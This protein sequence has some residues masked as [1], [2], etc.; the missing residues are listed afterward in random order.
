MYSYQKG[1]VKTAKLKR[2][3]VYRYSIALTLIAILSTIAFFNLFSALK[4]SDSTGIIVNISGKQRMLSQHIALDVYKIHNIKS[5]DTNLQLDTLVEELH[6]HTTEMALAN[7][8]L[9]TGQLSQTREYTLS[10][11]IKEMYFSD[12]N[13]S[14]RVKYYTQLCSRVSTTTSHHEIDKILEEINGLSE[15]L[16][17][18]LNSVVLQYQKEGEQ[19]LATIRT[20]ETIAWLFTLFVLLLE[21]LLIFHPMADKIKSLHEEKD[22]LLEHLEDNIEIRTRELQEANSKL[23]ELATHDPLTG[24][25]NRLSLEKDIRV[26]IEKSKRNSAP[27]AI[28]M[29]D[30]DWFKKVNDDY[31]H[32]VGDFVLQELAKILLASVRTEDSVYRFGGEE[33]VIL[34][35]RISYQ[36]SV[37][38]ANKIRLLVKNHTFNINAKTFSKTVS[39]GFYHSSMRSTDSYEEIMKLVDDALYNSKEQGRDQ[40]TEVSKIS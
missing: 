30:I 18:D 9:T 4:A 21:A 11:T 38:I 19:K 15:K 3:I 40:V 25:K 31:G 33:F 36:N 7:Q 16:L 24:L 5:E 39:G 17:I 27:Y 35:N 34:L 13:L 8:K 12:L 23:R 26:V 22:T 2:D 37:A 1:V 29:Y 14:K 6:S 32:I 10:D 20:I 28:L